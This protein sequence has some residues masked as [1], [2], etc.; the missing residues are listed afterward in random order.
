MQY[1]RL[2]K[3]EMQQRGI[4][5]RLKGIIADFKNPTRNG[6]RYTEELWDR[7]FDDPI[8]KEKIENRCI[9]GELG[10]PADRQETDIEMV[11]IC[12]AEMPKK[13]NDGKLHG[14]FDILDTP[15]GRILKT[16]CDYGCNIGVSSR[17]GGDTFEDY[18]GNET[19]DP[20]TYEFECF[21]AV[22]LPAV[23]AARPAY[24]TESFDTHKKTLKVA[25]QE[26]L[27]RST[28]EE[29][30]VMKNTMDELQLDY[31]PEEEL[32]ES[33]DNIDVAT[34]NVAAENDGADII[35][36]LQ[37][38][39]QRQQELEEQVRSL[40]E[41]LSVCYTKESRY[42]DRLGK[43][44]SKVVSQENENKMLS[45]K[46]EQLTTETTSLK[47]ANN[48]LTTT[49]KTLTESFDTCQKSLEEANTTI[50]GYRERYSALKNQLKE[51][52]ST[53]TTLDES[54]NSK[55]AE[56]KNLTEAYKTLKE[57]SQK[58]LQEAIA[59]TDALKSENKKLVE[60][61]QE[62]RKD[63]QILKSQSNAK[64]E[65]AQQLVEK[66]K[67]V[68]KTAVDKYIV[69]QATKIGVSVNDIKGR[70][71]ESYSFKDIDKAVSDLQQYKLN[72]NSLPF[73]TMSE[74]KPAKIQIRESKQPRL[75]NTS[76]NFDDDVDEALLTFTN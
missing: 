74:K 42:N 58:K 23:K 2:T 30:R 71:T 68:A 3:E 44:N 57:E 38:A 54:L 6:R 33:G 20:S 45:E 13:G 51:S 5:G 39:L 67:A 40:Q 41:K 32:S 11:A 28:E 9:L 24:V 53:K 73:T 62:T 26:A 27:Q 75:D 46:I 52:K 61:L 7:T 60:E 12:L 50:E 36:E 66:Y 21:D 15:N 18:D 14:I 72:L 56:V 29:Q 31:S 22:L 76:Y 43:A 59:T 49:V 63:S 48:E 34:E 4:L 16:L 55:S 8:V 10:H 17:G 35:N 64:L 70:L 69:S 47:E 1:Q 19:V 37:E 65:K 25:L